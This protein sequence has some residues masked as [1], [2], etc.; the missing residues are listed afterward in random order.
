MK[1]KGKIYLYIS[2][3]KANTILGRV[4]GKYKLRAGLTAVYGIST[5]PSTVFTLQKDMTENGK[6]I[7]A[8]LHK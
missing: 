4:S 8:E 3:A 5:S 7:S 2:I 1:D 6:G